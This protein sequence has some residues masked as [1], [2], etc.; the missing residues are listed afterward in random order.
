[1]AS[2]FILVD[3]VHAFDQIAKYSACSTASEVFLTRTARD[4]PP[5]M[6]WHVKHNRALQENVFVLN[7]VTESIPWVKN[8]ERLLVTEVHPNYWRATA[9]VRLYGKAGYSGRD[10]TGVPA[11]LP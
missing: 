1:V 7:A 11:K 3:E 8:S 10:Q 2:E 6:L 5:V 4:A 9:P